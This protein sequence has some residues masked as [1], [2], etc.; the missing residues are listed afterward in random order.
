MMRIL[1][2]CLLALAGVAGYIQIES[3]PKWTA[4]A[5]PTAAKAKMHKLAMRII[6]KHPVRHLLQPMGSK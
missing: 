4:F 6:G 3:Q 2:F 5:M 1:S